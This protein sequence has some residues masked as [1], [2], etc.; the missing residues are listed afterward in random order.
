[1]IAYLQILLS[2]L[3]N[4]Q[5]TG[6]TQFGGARIV[7]FGVILYCGERDGQSKGMLVVGRCVMASGGGFM[8]FL[9]CHTCHKITHK[10]RYMQEVV[11]FHV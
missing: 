9:F 8:V 2:K 4:F 10:L 6:F 11:G 5:Q 7:I 1:M 3:D